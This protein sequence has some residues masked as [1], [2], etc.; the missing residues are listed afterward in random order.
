[1][2][3]VLFTLFSYVTELFCTYF[4]MKKFQ[5]EIIKPL[6]TKLE[7]KSKNLLSLRT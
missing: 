2:T 6:M 1:M 4:E 7:K 3:Q 5:N